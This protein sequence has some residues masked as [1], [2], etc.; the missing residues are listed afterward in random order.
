M[1][2]CKKKIDSFATM[3]W[4]HLFFIVLAVLISAPSIAQSKKQL[5]NQRKQIQNEIKQ[6]QSLL[7]KSKKEAEALLSDLDDLNKIISVRSN[8][9]STINAEAE[10]LSQ[11]IAKNEKEIVK[12]E[13]NLDV[14]KKDYADM[15]V[16]SYKSKSKQSRLMFLLS[17]ESFGQ[18]YKR[19]Q[20]MKQYANY[21]KKQGEE[22]K[23]TSQS[24]KKLNDSLHIKEDEKQL[25]I[26]LNLKE[27]DSIKSEKLSQER[28]VTKVRAKEK[29][30]IAQIDKKQKEQ[31]ELD[32]KIEQLIAAAI[33]KS[34]KSNS[35]SS[36]S[37]FA[38][39]PEE[40][41]LAS[42]FVANKG[43]LPWPVE[44]GLV[45]RK[46]GTQKHPTMAGI[47]IQSNGVHMATVEDG[48]ARSVF[49][50]KVMSI[51]LMPGTHQKM[52]LIQ[53]G[54]YISVYKNLDKVLVKPNQ[55]I[56]TKQDIG[57]I[58]TDAVTGKTI[59]AFSLVK[60]NTFQDPEPWIAKAI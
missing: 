14:L 8:L 17:S 33:A 26:A 38:L 16:N 20:Y 7:F 12:L 54:N 4:H 27:Q 59:L 34:K 32:K 31:R 15:I 19:Y 24:L 30:Y 9:I 3:K 25:L 57:T 2:R 28:L 23:T 53:H 47:T 60:E 45:V 46:Y 49:D 35:T 22:I 11:E 48:K 18:A 55:S 1:I 39:T 56:N 42:S 40:K 36:S 43:K 10:R 5:E 44:K 58:H 41:V 21:R 52:V 6:T 29:E 37:G 13:K 50:G 51:V